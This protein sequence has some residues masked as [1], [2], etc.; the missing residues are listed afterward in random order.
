MLVLYKT[1]PG[2]PGVESYSLREDYC[3]L[4]SKERQEEIPK[5]RVQMN[6]KTENISFPLQGHLWYL[7]TQVLRL[8]MGTREGISWHNK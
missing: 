3:Q 1:T 2:V 7:S 4:P 5:T 6:S 8:H